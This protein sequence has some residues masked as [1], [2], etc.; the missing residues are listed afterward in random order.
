MRKWLLAG[1]L[2]LGFVLRVILLDKSPVGFTADEASF[3]YDAY[4]IIKTGRDQWGSTFP[5]VLKSFGDFKSPLYAYLTIPF[6]FVLGLTKFAVRLPNA[7]L[8]AIA[9][10]FVYL[11]SGEIGKLSELDKKKRSLLQLSASFLLAVSPWHIMM[12]RGAFEANLITIF[13]PASIYFFLKGLK[14]S[15]LLILSALLFGLNLFTY[16]SAKLITPIVILGL[17][18]IFRR[19]ISKLRLKN[20]FISLFVFLVFFCGFLYTFSLGGGARISERS[21]TQGALEEG[22]KEKIALI[23]GGKDPLISKLLHNKYQT[24]AKRFILNYNQYFSAKFLFIK[25]AGETTYGMLP[26]GVLYIF[27]G[28]LFLGVIYCL[29][30]KKLRA[31]VIPLMLWLLI[32]PLPAA[33]ATGIGYS[34]NRAEGM[35]PS[36]QILGAFGL[37]GWTYLVSK[38]NRK[39]VICLVVLLCGLASFEISKFA[40]YYFQKGDIAAKGML[41]GSLEVAEWLSKSSETKNVIVSRSISEPQIF[42]A[43]V[44]KWDPSDFQ[45]STKT[46]GFDESD[47]SWVDQIPSYSLGNYTFKSVDWKVDTDTRN[48]TIVARPEE[49]PK[50]IVPDKVFTYTNGEDAIYV[51]NY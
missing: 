38:I 17:L 42:V 48:T 7:L 37:I 34:G 1:I 24:V 46:W 4:S 16:H 40:I 21:I 9:V 23:Q 41:Y 32:A 22:A 43:F 3:G 5:L 47:L 18:V 14:N 49:F 26:V 20:I 25:G 35:I 6:V 2:I 36:L 31:V 44:N 50:N 33:L 8:G 39:L 51:K 28:I 45:A 15:K 19:E 29:F 12:S 13:L 11:L 30:Q 27:E 10:Y